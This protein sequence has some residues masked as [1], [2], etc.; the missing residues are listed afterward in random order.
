[1]GNKN[2]AKFS[3]E[4][5]LSLIVLVIEKELLKLIMMTCKV[6]FYI[7]DWF[8]EI[9]V[10]FVDCGDNWQRSWAS[11]NFTISHPKIRYFDGL[12]NKSPISLALIKVSSLMA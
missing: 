3:R 6:A 11:E 12:M 10:N 5:Q 1:M 7:I 9:L 8:T 4:R 2:E